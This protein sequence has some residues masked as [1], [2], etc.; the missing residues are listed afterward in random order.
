MLGGESLLSRNAQ[1][2]L[3]VNKKSY[4]IQLLRFRSSSLPEPSVILKK[5]S[6]LYCALVAFSLPPGLQHFGG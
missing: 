5:T 1:L 4:C 6:A 3:C 2:E